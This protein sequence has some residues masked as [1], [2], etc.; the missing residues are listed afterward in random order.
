MFKSWIAGKCILITMKWWKYDTYRTPGMATIFFTDI[1]SMHLD[2]INVTSLERG[3]EEKN[4]PF[5]ELCFEPLQ[6][7]FHK[8]R[9]LCNLAMC[10]EFNQKEHIALRLP[11]LS[12]LCKK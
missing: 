7:N 6:Y 4:S 9:Q 12:R 5:P 8:H 3:F 2:I 11:C 1:Q 10:N